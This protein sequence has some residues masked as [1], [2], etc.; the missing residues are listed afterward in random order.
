MALFKGIE[1]DTHGIKK[2]VGDKLP[3]FVLLDKDMTP[4]T[5]ADFTEKIKVFTLV[6]SVDTGV[7]DAQTRKFNEMYRDHPNVVAI[8]VSMDLPFAL[9]RFCGTAGIENAITLSD[10]QT[11]QFGIDLGVLFEGLRL[12]QRAVI[13]VDSNDHIT[14]VEYMEESRDAVNFEA[15]SDAV[16]KLL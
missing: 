3:Q 1:I 10:Y 7:C 11:G 4:K 14:Y 15:A 9:A 2:T 12:F 8:T 5:N 13:V 6:P 16:T